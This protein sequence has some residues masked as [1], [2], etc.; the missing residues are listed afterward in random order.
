MPSIIQTLAELA[1]HFPRDGNAVK[2][3]AITGLLRRGIDVAAHRHDVVPLSTTE[4]ALS[5]STLALFYVGWRDVF[6]ETHLAQHMW[7]NAKVAC[8]AMYEKCHRGTHLD[9][10][11]RSSA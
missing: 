7:H 2:C 3:C 1:S 6:T 11:E 9:P 8:Q 10:R 5:L 4:T